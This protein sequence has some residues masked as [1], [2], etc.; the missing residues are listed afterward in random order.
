METQEDFLDGIEINMY[1]PPVF[2][3][4]FFLIKFHG[5]TI[6][7]FRFGNDIC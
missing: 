5:E 7:S 3:L 6:H 2:E 1:S 4:C